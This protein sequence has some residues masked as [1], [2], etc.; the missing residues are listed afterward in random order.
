[1]AIIFNE[2]FETDGNGTRY[3]TSTPEFSDGFSDFFTRAD[4]SAISSSYEV[5]GVAGSFFFAAQDIDGE[6]AAPE[7]T[8][9]LTGIDIS[10]ASNLSF[11]ALF[12]EDDS[13]DGNED[14]DGGSD[15][16][17][18]RVEYQIDGGGYQNLF[19]IE[20]DGSTFNSAPFVDTDFDGIGDGAEITSVFTR[21]SAAF[22]Q[23]GSLLDLRFT[24]NLEDGDEDIAID[25]ITIEGDVAGPVTVLSEGFETDGNGTRYA[26]SVAEFS[27]GFGDYFTRTDGSNI[28]SFVEL[29]GAEGDFFFAAQDIDGEGAGP[30]QT[31]EFTGLDIS[32]LTD[33]SFSALFA[34]DDASDGNEDWDG[35]SD[36]NFVR[37]E[38]QID[39]GGFQTFFAIENDGSTFNSAP[40]VDTDLDGVGDGAEITDAF[41]RY[42]AALAGTGSVLDLRITLNLEDGDED[43]ALDDIMVVGQ[44]GGI[45]PP[46]VLAVSGDGL[47]VAEEGQTTDTFTLQLATDPA[48][49][50]TVTVTADAQTEVSL[51]GTTFAS[52]IDVDLIDA[53]T[54][55]TLTVRA[56]DDAV[57]ETDTHI[58]EIS[59]A[60]SSEDPGYAG[61]TLSPL[62]VDIADNDT[63]ITKI[64]DIQ[65]AGDSSDLEGQEVT[66][67]AIVTGLFYDNSGNV[68]GFY[69]QEEDAD[70]DADT[71]TSE[72]V[73]V[74]SPDA[75]VAVGDKV[76]VTGIVDEQFGK[77]EIEASATSVIDSGNTLPSAV[78]ITLG[79]GLDFEPLE[80]MR[81][82]LMSDPSTDPLTVV[83]NFNLDRFGEIQVANGNLVQPTQI[84]DPD[85]QLAEI[86]ALSEANENGRLI[87][88]DSA[89]GSN[90]NVYR[91]L[92]GPDGGPVSPT[93]FDDTAQLLRLGTELEDITG[94]M[95]FDFG[96]Y[97]LQVT[98]PLK[99][100]DA[101][102]RP[103]EA[104]DVGGDLKVAS[105]NV[106]NFFT[107]L[108]GGTVTN[109]TGQTRGASS[110]FDL[111]RQTDKLVNAISE[112]DADILGLQ[113][114]ENNGFGSASA[115]ATLVDALNAASAPGTYAFVQPAGVTAEGWVGS[116]AITT[117][118]IYKPEAVSLVGDGQ[119]L[120]FEEASAA[121][122]LATAS[123][124]NDFVSSDDLVGDFQRNRPAVAATFEDAEGNQVT[125]VSNHFK[126]KGDSNLEDTLIDAQN[127]GAP[128]D[129]IDALLADPNYDQGDGQGFWNQ[130]R[131]DAAAELA[132][133][134]ETNPTGATD[135]SNVL[136]LGDLNSY[137]KENPVTTLEGAGYTDLAEEFIGD[138]AY[139]FVF[140]GQRG[141]LDYGLASGDILDNITGVAEW[142]VAADEPDLLNY[143]SRFNDAAYFNGD[144]VFAASDHDPLIIGLDLTEEPETMVARLD[145]IDRRFSDKLVYS[146]DGEVVDTERLRFIQRDVEVEA[147]GIR[148]DSDDGLKWSPSFISSFGPGIGVWSLRGDRFSRSERKLVEEKET[149]SFELDDAGGLGDA[150]EVG[151]EFAKVRGSGDVELMFF[152]DGMLVAEVL[153]EIENGAVRHGLDSG[154]TF[155]EVTIGAT[156][157]LRFGVDAIEFVR[158]VIEDDS[159]V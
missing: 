106:L 122:T 117:G 90:P 80:G 6:G 152:E 44:S 108:G 57:D 158:T 12:A 28:G 1:M 150:V 145:I 5:T 23:V 40:F 36:N 137:A 144:D 76:Q 65:G 96:S 21:Y 119:I 43:I 92:E 129:L 154:Q 143:S 24:F 104:P 54:A 109:P 14:W 103:T 79:I 98:D 67:E 94:I 18:L 97:R 126:S 81:V 85:T 115:I 105:F 112:I 37:L 87:V 27:D 121:Q 38:Y 45:A 148:I 133:W 48:A 53:A 102:P 47:T 95:D 34:E 66:V 42:T 68:R 146:V 157:N 19:A 134:L 147:A 156:D 111:D 101:N 153:L 73:F 142:H 49:P 135:P 8:L 52:S 99:T 3:I 93:N 72:G 123:A 100:I 11:S 25:D 9:T 61:L 84:F 132:A 140:D 83:T 58:G 138:D 63:T 16:N 91:L 51:D 7:Q 78:A 30:E 107:S 64:H 29:T 10:G 130:V 159:L 125:I 71:L 62:T 120:V 86:Q 127:A 33:L 89:S 155:D 4:G 128:Q 75:T 56:V 2:S 50:V 41:T 149:L 15:N 136:V 124:L 22:A 131:A 82:E 26:T 39:G 141:T 110:E 59:F 139:S 46:A 31:I 55:A 77:T 13:S 88:D 69:L 32:G 35:G 151:F 114:L 70:V 113:E 116:D 20:N 118:I 60:I 74:F 17:F